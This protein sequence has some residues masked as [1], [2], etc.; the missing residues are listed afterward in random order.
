MNQVFLIIQNYIYIIV[1]IIHRNNKKN[2]IF[3]Q[4]VD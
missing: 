1:L 2:K 4:I 3:I